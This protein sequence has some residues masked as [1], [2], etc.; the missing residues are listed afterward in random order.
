MLS[1]TLR[2]LSKGLKR[3]HYR[4]FPDD[5]QPS[6]LAHFMAHGL[7]TIVEIITPLV[8]L[9]VN[10][11]VALIAVLLMVCFHLFILS[12]FPPAAPLEWNALFAYTTV[13]LFL[14]FG[15]TEGFLGSWEMSR[16]SGRSCS[17]RLAWCSSR[18]WAICGPT[19]CPF[20]PSMRQYAGNW[21]SA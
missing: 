18:S 20:L 13:F 10:K 17:S 4:N 21:A 14:G 5:L 1:N 2:V 19:W 15:N 16:T 6:G 11:T 7:G 8:L 9:F 3:A 12:T